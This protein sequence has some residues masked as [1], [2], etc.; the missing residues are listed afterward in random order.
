MTRLALILPVLLLTLL[1]ENPAF[2]DF[3]EGKDAYDKGGAMNLAY[4][5]IT[6]THYM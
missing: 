1:V 6:H 3:Q 4:P 2:A 5:V